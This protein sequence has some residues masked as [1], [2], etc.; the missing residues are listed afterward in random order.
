MNYSSQCRPLWADE[1]SC[2]GSGGDISEIATV[3]GAAATA[4][5]SAN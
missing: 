3:A 2:A 4:A 1:C 5:E